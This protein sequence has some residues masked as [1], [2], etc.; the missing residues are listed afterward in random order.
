M[1]QKDNEEDN[2]YNE[3]AEHQ[4]NVE[5]IEMIDSSLRMAYS[6]MPLG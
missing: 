3:E 4:Q 2:I 1:I 6:N 5:V